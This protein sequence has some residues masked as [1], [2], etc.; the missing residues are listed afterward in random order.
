MAFGLFKKKKG[1]K[2]KTDVIQLKVHEVVKETAEAVSIHFE[3][4]ED[5]KIEYKPGQYFTLIFDIEGKEER[6]SYSV[7]SSPYTDEHP[8]V[9]VKRVEG[10]TVSNH[11]NDNLKAGDE[12]RVIPP[13]GNFTTEVSS[14]NERT[15]ALIG[16]GSGITPLMSIAKSILDQEP[17]SRLKLL[18][19]NQSV[20]AIIFKDELEALEKDHEQFEIIHTLEKNEGDYAQYEGYVTKD[21][22]AD[23]IKKVDDDKAEYFVCGPGPMMDLSIDALKELG[24]DEK[25]IHKESFTADSN[26]KN[27]K[28]AEVDEIV[29]RE[30]TVIHDDEEYKYM[31][32]PNETI[33]EKGLDE[34]IDLPFSCQSGL[35]TA[36]RGKC[37]SGKVKMDEYSG[38]SDAE[39]E[40]G[41]VLPCQSHPLTDDV[42]IEIG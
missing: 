38:L 27:V 15:L 12:I 3:H 2:Q 13:L 17:K 18:Y 37:V 24:V 7:C 41:Y 31:V 39:L 23:L 14:E 25:K 4:P 11:I 42:V 34:N 36:C 1:N 19:A 30:V 21:I 5:G 20:D 26:S 40:D 8:A 32:E 10:G 28:P 16:G 22:I 33:L 29:A 35:C 9:A 6:R